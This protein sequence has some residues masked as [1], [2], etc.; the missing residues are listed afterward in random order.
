SRLRQAIHVGTVREPR[1]GRARG[2]VGEGIDGARRILARSGPAQV[3]VSDPARAEASGHLGADEVAWIERDEVALSEGA[4]DVF[5]V[6]S[7]TTVAVA[8]IDGTTTLT[9]SGSISS[10]WMIDRYQ[11]V[12]QLGEGGCGIVYEAEQTKPIRRRVALKVI[13]PGRDSAAVLARFAME[14]QALAA[15]DHVGI[16]KVLDAGTTERGRPYFVMELVRGDPITAFCDAKRLGVDERVRLFVDLCE[17]IQHA[18]AKGVIHRDIKPSNVLVSTDDRGTPRVRVIDFGIAKA[19]TELT[20]DDGVVTGIGEIIGTPAYMSPEQASGGTIDVDIRS[21]VY[22]LGVVLFELLTGVRPFSSANLSASTPI[23][24]TRARTNPP[25]PSA[26]LVETQKTDRIALT[27]STEVASLLKRLRRD[28]DWVVLKALDPERERRYQ[29]AAGFAEELRRY[30]SGEPVEAGP[31]TLRYRASKYVRRH[32]GP[33][34]AAVALT[35][36]LAVACGALV[37]ALN[38]QAAARRAELATRQEK[39]IV[40]GVRDRVVTA[41]LAPDQLVGSGRAP[42]RFVDVLRE[43]HAS[44]ASV[45]FPHDRVEREV[46][47]ALGKALVRAGAP[48]LGAENLERV[49]ELRPREHWDTPVRLEVLSLLQAL[50]DLGRLDEATARAQRVSREFGGSAA[51][52]RDFRRQTHQMLAMAY[53]R[54]G[55]AGRAVEMLRP[56]LAELVATSDDAIEIGGA[57]LNLAIAL[58]D[59]GE[60]DEARELLESVVSDW[61]VVAPRSEWLV[62]AMYERGVVGVRAGD[63]EAAEVWLR[64]ALGLADEVLAPLHWRTLQAKTSLGDVVLGRGESVEAVRLLREATVG[65]DA[66]GAPMV[67]QAIEARSRL[68]RALAADGHHEDAAAEAARL[69]EQADACDRCAPGVRDAARATA[70]AYGGAIDA[71]GAPK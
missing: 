41:I 13:K 17:A 53:R 19:L 10:A 24:V 15:M 62:Q 66:G 1:D 67:P 65:Y 34:A 47:S 40:E 16:A 27:R 22:A 18:H 48:D 70:A 54:S 21:D 56:V 14:R 4:V 59:R 64:E 37:W 55:D 20:G 44:L 43:A 3:L 61:R 46:R 2:H 38:E 36:A 57:Q 32:R 52:V 9:Q 39:Q 23:E 69:M 51:E 31:P 12:G 8:D 45:T 29:T 26:R 33:L 7:D 68:V 50:I 49:L 11:I 28:L 30:L 25:R 71:G 58:G 60:Y 35:V 5:S 63:L 6:E 42:E